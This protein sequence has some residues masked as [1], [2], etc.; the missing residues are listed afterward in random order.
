MLNTS[1]FGSNI[2]FGIQACAWCLH[3]PTSK[4][5]PNQKTRRNYQHVLFV[6]NRCIFQS[7][8]E[9]CYRLDLP[10]A[11]EPKTFTIIALDLLL[12]YRNLVIPKQRRNN[13][14]IENE[15]ESN[16]NCLL[17]DLFINL[18]LRFSA[19]VWLAHTL[20]AVSFQV[21]QS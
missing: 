17:H 21:F 2:P 18:K 5:W 15:F 3:M 1:R 13:F 14:V 10:N 20:C 8:S 12:E 9:Q 19:T 6:Q 4:P 11:Y 16:E 7:L